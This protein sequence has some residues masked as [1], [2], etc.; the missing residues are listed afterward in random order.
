MGNSRT[1]NLAFISLGANLG[2]PSINLLRAFDRLQTFSAAPLLR[3]SLWKSVPVDCP[4]GSPMFVNAV[5]GLVPLPIETPASLLFKLQQIEKEFGRERKGGINEPR[6]L[7][8]DL[9]TFGQ[10][11]ISER[12]L[13]LPHPRAHLR[14]FVLAPLAELA[15]ELVLP[16][17]SSTVRE[18]LGS[19]PPDQVVEKISVQTPK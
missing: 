7:D 15:P 18:L 9:L 8:L 5:A 2:N 3:S 1:H 17:Q 16:G 6:P 14:R 13:V 12:N 4:P 10:E 11:V 19:L